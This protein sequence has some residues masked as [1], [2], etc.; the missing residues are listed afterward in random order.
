MNKPL[1][2]CLG[3]FIFLIFFKQLDFQVGKL[4]FIPS[5]ENYILIS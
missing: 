2:V 1:G 5:Q 3:S 4:Y